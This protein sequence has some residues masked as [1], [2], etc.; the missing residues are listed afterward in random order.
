[1][2][3]FCLIKQYADEFKARIKSGE[4]NPE[5]LANKPSKEL[6]K[7][8]ET[9]LPK[10]IAKD[11]NLLLEKKLA[12]KNVESGII[13]WAESL[14]GV[15]T[16]QRAEFLAKAKKALEER[17]KRIFSPEDEQKFLEEYV[18]DSLGIAVTR[19]ESDLILSMS[20]K[21]ED[22]KKML[23]KAGL[24][25]KLEEIKGKVSDKEAAVID[26]VLKRVKEKDESI[27]TSTY[28]KRQKQSIEDFIN[29]KITT[30]RQSDIVSA[31][32]IGQM[33]ENER[34]DFLSTIF[35]D[36]EVK[37]I[38]SKF[39]EK[40]SQVTSKKER[41]RQVGLI[42]RFI[43]NKAKKVSKVSTSIREL[44]KMSENERIDFLSKYFDGEELMET[45]DK[46]EATTMVK[47]LNRKSISRIKNYLAG[48]NPSDAVKK[49]V[50]DLVDTIVASRRSNIEYGASRV[51]LDNLIGDIKI[52][53][54]K[55]WKRDRLFL[56]EENFAKVIKNTAGFAKSVVSSID[57]SILLR[58][59]LPVLFSG[60]YKIWAKGLAKSFEILIKSLGTSKNVLDGVK[61]EIYGR[62]NSINGNYEK[63]KLDVGISEEAFPTSL[64]ERIW[65]LG[66]LFKASQEAFT[67][68]AFYVRAELADK[69][70]AQKKKIGQEMDDEV[71]E[72]LGVYIN[73]LTGR[74]SK[75]LGKIGET[76]NAL[77]F[78]PKF[79][80]SR[81]D[82][83]TGHMFDKRV[84]GAERFRAAKDIAF[85]VGHIAGILYLANKAFPGQVSIETD[86][87]S[88]DIGKLKLGDTRID[89][90]G[91]LA[92][93]VTLASRIAAIPMGKDSYK[94]SV[95]GVMGNDK[96]FGGKGATE[97]LGEFAGNKLSPLFGLIAD[98]YQGE[99]FDKEP[100]TMEALKNNP[101]EV[102]W[103]AFKNTFVP[104]PAQN[105]KENLETFGFGPKLLAFTI[106]D[107][108]GLG[109]NTYSYSPKWDVN[110]GVELKA[111]QE[112]VGKETFQ[113]END[114]FAK[115]M[116]KYVTTVR[117]DQ[118]FRNLSNDEKK[119]VLEKKADEYKTEIYKKNK[120][121]YKQVRDKEKTKRIDDVVNINP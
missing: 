14:T 75:W 87:R 117:D 102:T 97:Y 56:N 5:V 86:P 40:L 98:I 11:V 60:N 44:Q 19:E 57:N 24:R 91:G 81:I 52:K 110:K 82:I 99:D 21:L 45:L 54:E 114:E 100:Y 38:S 10:D 63:M 88:S 89:V 93:Y 37:E 85:I 104:L 9:F 120:F 77:F 119:R 62:E 84:K 17:K 13:R 58:Q 95:T 26:E 106:T 36:K 32:K 69:L 92:G 78:S 43:E 53:S 35:S 80:Q 48:E 27:F 28:T 112:K 18:E 34:T 64:P 107:G 67:G 79:A 111:F 115:K 55:P 42:K 66:R 22:G 8:F 121:V 74:G 96:D 46:I 1:M 41:D 2:K 65:G 29:R 4:I 83:L 71:A 47:E 61:A 50:S 7:Y 51:A 94:S 49:E 113:K 68:T 116:H 72:S 105:F 30:K 12:N 20:K 70:I 108:L 101:T 39:N 59:L 33:S 73:S 90:T 3:E 23:T 15:T 118:K 109:T 76:G 31:T 6:G 16:K 25:K 103:R